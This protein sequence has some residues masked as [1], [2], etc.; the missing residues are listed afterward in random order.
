MFP[1]NSVAR[2]KHQTNLWC[3]IALHVCFHFRLLIFSIYHARHKIMNLWLQT[4]LEEVEGLKIIFS[5]FGVDFFSSW[6]PAL[7]TIVSQWKQQ[8]I[9]SR[10]RHTDKI[11]LC[12][13]YNFIVLFW[14]SPRLKTTKIKSSLFQSSWFFASY[15][16]V[17]FNF[18]LKW[19]QATKTRSKFTDYTFN[20]ENETRNV[21]SEAKNS[22]EY[23]WLCCHKKSEAF[24]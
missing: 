12:L 2:H 20:N 5:T 18:G 16:K 6:F 15:R 14:F 1:K 13:I 22:F 3:C 4:L 9:E 17:F 10:D 24:N 7:W 23:F 8:K 11:L 19:H 21:A